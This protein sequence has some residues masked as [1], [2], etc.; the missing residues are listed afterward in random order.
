MRV[1][2]AAICAA[3]I[4]LSCALAECL[5]L[6]WAF[7]KDNSHSEFYAYVMV[8]MIVAKIVHSYIGD[9]WIFFLPLRATGMPRLASGYSLGLNGLSGRYNP[10]WIRPWNLVFLI[11][12]IQKTTYRIIKG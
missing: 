1:T 4:C 11:Q 12:Y 6:G 8:R 2:V 5:I 3:S 7:T 10:S 9:P